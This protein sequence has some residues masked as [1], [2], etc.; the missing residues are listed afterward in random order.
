MVFLLVGGSAWG[1]KK[2]SVS[3][4]PIPPLRV[5]V[6]Q[7]ET[8]ASQ[9]GVEVYSLS[10]K[11]EIFSYKADLPLNPASNTKLLTTAAALYK[12]GPDF[13]YG[14]R[15]LTDS[16]LGSGAI[17]NL[18]VVGSG[19][20]TL[21][22]GRTE[23]SNE[24]RISDIA[25]ELARAGVRE[26][27]GDIVVDQSFFDGQ[28][29]GESMGDK[30]F[31]TKLTAL[32]VN[33]NQF[34]VIVSPGSPPNVTLDQPTSYFDLQ[35]SVV[36]GKGSVVVSKKILGGREV[37]SV[38]GAYR[39]KRNYEVMKEVMSPGLFGGH[40]I[41]MYLERAG[42][43][44]RGT[45][46]EGDARGEEIYVSYS[47]PLST[48]IKTMNKRSINFTA[49]MVLKTLGAH[50]KGTPG[51]T[52][53][54]VSVV[55]EYLRT[56][57]CSTDGCLLENGSGLSRVTR[58]SA[59]DITQMLRHVEKQSWM[60][61]FE[62][63]LAIA[64]IDG[65]VRNRLKKPG[66]LGQAFVKTGTLN[67]ATSLAGYFTTRRGEKLAFTILA[68]GNGTNAHRMH[69]LQEKILLSLADD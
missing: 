53:G 57:G 1:A 42:V 9:I 14:T 36:N 65:T 21:V 5:L 13:R 29:F 11:R 19:D 61:D 39:G 15:F 67:N 54:G 28:S 43:V 68:S 18:Y 44:V 58:I 51:T 24:T 47:E 50:F 33:F 60:S 45:V 31:R 30:T 37:V 64:G 20:P 66:L 27:A 26:I 52:P 16:Q 7:Y 10:K 49:E 63:S 25:A 41:K 55:M 12:L 8:G 40:M 6:P 17:H 34:S 48:I 2:K 35:P 3:N 23:S 4:A 56:A 38:R 32:V 59:H 69:E 62:A 46:R 22:Q